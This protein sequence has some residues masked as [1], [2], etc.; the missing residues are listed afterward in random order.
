MRKLVH[1]RIEEISRGIAIA[2]GLPEDKMPEVRFPESFTPALYNNPELV[3][4]IW[5]SGVRVL[6]PE[7]VIDEPPQMVGE[8]FS[9][10]GSTE[11]NVPTVMMWLGTVPSTRIQNGDLPGLHSP[12]YYPDPERSIETGVLVTTTALIDLF[13]GK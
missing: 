9:R 8:D 13:N 4:R 1:K 7:H 3:D 5:N 11:H 2:A 6:G 12:F 10:Y